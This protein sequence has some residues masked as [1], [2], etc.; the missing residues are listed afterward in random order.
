MHSGLLTGAMTR[1]RVMYMPEND[2]RK[3][4]KQYQEPFLSR[5]LDLAELLREIGATHDVSAGVVAIA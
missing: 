5:N 1:E 3:R 4:A 2:F